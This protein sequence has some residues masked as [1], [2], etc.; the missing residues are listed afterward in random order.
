MRIGF[1]TSSDYP[2]LS[3]SDRLLAKELSIS[4]VD[5]V[6][7]I[8]TDASL[9]D[10]LDLLVFRSCW[11]YSEKY[12]EFLCFLDKL[13]DQRVPVA[14]SPTLVRWNS[15]KS[16]LI[17][18]AD[19]GVRTVPSAPISSPEEV[20]IAIAT[21]GEGSLVIKPQVGASGRGVQ[22]LSSEDVL[23]VVKQEAARRSN[24]QGWLLQKFMSEIRQG[25]Y[26]LVFIA[27]EFSHAVLKTPQPSEFRINTR[28]RGNVAPVSPATELVE[29]AQIM[30][31]CLNETPLYARVDGV[32]VEGDFCLC[33]LELIEP[34]L[35]FTVVSEAVGF[36][37]AAIRQAAVTLERGWN[38]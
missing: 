38:G 14:N 31:H 28:Y 24:P 10:D 26:S 6:P 17:E 18:L 29:Q 1:V 12:D 5:V 8:W 25:E 32:L 13:G 19:A 7:V 34:S 20:S 33:E 23:E 4:G 27:G 36:A 16:Y 35:Y 2:T 30:L 37:A 9:P 22:R 21:L 15:R 11:D 3:A